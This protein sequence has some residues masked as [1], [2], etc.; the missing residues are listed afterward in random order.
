MRKWREGTSHKIVGCLFICLCILAFTGSTATFASD[1][2]GVT[3]MGL[4]DGAEYCSP[5]PLSNTGALV[6]SQTG[7]GF[8]VQFFLDSH[9]MC[10]GNTSNFILLSSIAS[11]EALSQI[12]SPGTHSLRVSLLDLE[13]RTEVAS[14]EITY[15][16]LDCGDAC[17][18]AKVVAT[19]PAPEEFSAGSV[20][21]IAFDGNS[22]WASCYGCGLIYELGFDDSGNLV[23]LDS[24]D[25]PSTN[26]TGITFVGRNLFAGDDGTKIISKIKT[27]GRKAGEV[28]DMFYAPGHPSE[29]CTGLTF[30]KGRLWNA[31]FVWSEVGGAIHKIKMNGDLEETFFFPDWDTPEGLAFDG[32]FIWLAEYGQN[33]IYKLNVNDLTPVCYFDGP[34]FAPIGLTFDGKYLW[35]ADQGT[36]SFYKID[37]ALAN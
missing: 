3:I 36:Q 5:I 28:Q 31:D 14:A 2:V 17:L 26:P 37:I 32:Q 16:V 18:N 19:Y 7:D 1:D 6:E 23:V 15:K 34:G 9:L 24:I 21:G 25:A 10:D 29:D 33:R 35:L 12:S 20:H 13:T 22:L 27:T 11:T 4:T 30:A 8:R